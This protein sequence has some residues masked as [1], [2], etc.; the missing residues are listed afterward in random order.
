MNAPAPEAGA[1]P[2]PD[3]AGPALVDSII[4]IPELRDYQ[5]INAELVQRLDRG[6]RR[7]RL[8]GAEGQRLLLAGLVG[9]WSALVEIEGNAGP[10]LAAGL[11]APGLTVVA[12]G[13]SAD[14]A[15]AG[16]RSG[17][18][19]LKNAT[20]D[21]LAMGQEGGAILAAAAAGHRAGLGQ[22]GGVLV[23]LGPVGRLA[24]ERQA[25]GWLFAYRDQLGPHTGHGRRGGALLGLEHTAD[26]GLAGAGADAEILRAELQA[27]APWL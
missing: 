25:G 8:H 22:R 14:G 12:R 15:G 1:A 2:D 17:R 26:F 9:G 27:A 4:A 24:G 19:I 16:L 5:R 10:E 23:L 7:V 11:N 18:L 13:T 21:A 6:D 20:G 3:A